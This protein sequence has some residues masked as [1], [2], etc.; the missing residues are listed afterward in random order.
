[1]T[2]PFE[3]QIA[4]VTGAGRGIGAAT[5]KRLAADGAHVVLTA[6]TAKELERV[7]EEIFE[8]GGSATI[9]P[10][11]LT[12]GDN[13]GRLASALS[14]RWDALDILVLNAGT[15]GSLT[16]VSQI[17][18]K[19]FSEVMTLNLMA[20]QAMLAAFDSM[21]KASKDARVVALTSSVGEKPRAY[22]GAYGA[23][24]AAL[25]T[26]IAAYADEV[27]NISNIRVAI[28]DPGAT[29]TKMRSRAYPGEDPMTV[30]KPATVAD[31]IADFL[32]QDFETGA[33]VRFNNIG[34]DQT[35]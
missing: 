1:M 10:M 30:K 34:E 33:R 27:R 14:Q 29:R 6:R 21:L 18:A 32:N 28:V 16:P 20:N 22:W 35:A 5:A 19:Q 23:S 11:D 24:K 15:L 9:A 31:A 17:D 2:K 7:E 4:L 13:I 8:A 25:D 12:D 3:G 26:L